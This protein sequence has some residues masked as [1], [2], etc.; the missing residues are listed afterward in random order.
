MNEKMQVIFIKQTGHVLAAFTR[1]ADPEGKP[2]VEALVGTG[3]I[4]RNKK[5]ILPPPPAIAPTGETIFV[6]SDSLDVVAVDFDPETFTSP[7]TFAAG[8]GKVE[9]L[10]SIAPP[11]ALTLAEDKLTITTTHPNDLKIWAQVQ[12]V[13]TPTDTEQ[14]TRVMEGIIEK[15][16]TSADLTLTIFPGGPAATIPKPADYYVL[17]LVEGQRPFFTK[18]SL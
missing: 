2:A 3:L 15:G 13:P 16:A 4:I 1:G 9:L 18:K 8:G 7:L 6:P 12:K 5:Q 14:M 10:G 17:V 11:S